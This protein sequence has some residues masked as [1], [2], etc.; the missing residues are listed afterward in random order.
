MRIET[1][2]ITIQNPKIVHNYFTK[3]LAGDFFSI[4][5]ISGNTC[6]VVKIDFDLA[7]AE[8]KYK[9]D[10][11]VGEINCTKAHFTALKSASFRQNDWCLVLEDDA[12]ISTD[13]PL[14]ITE[15]FACSL[16]DIPAIILLGHS[17]TVARYLWFQN[18]KQFK[19]NY[20]STPNF[21][22][23]KRHNANYCG[24]VGYL[25][26]APAVKILKQQKFLTHIA[27]DWTHVHKLGID[28]LHVSEPLVYEN[29][30]TKESSTGNQVFTHHNPFS[31]NWAR[32]WGSAIKAQ[33]YR[34]LSC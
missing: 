11:R 17:K 25:V 9:R 13:L 22:I 16:K 32:E 23:V 28:V 20:I 5:V 26:N 27:D 10:L 31:K 29:F 15:I 24:T 3:H 14:L 19:T 1:F 8:R 18:L 7:V 21:T 6:D 30:Q 2:I 4:T 33:L 34:V 12:L